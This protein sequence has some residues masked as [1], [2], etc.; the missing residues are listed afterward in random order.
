MLQYTSLAYVVGLP[1][2]VHLPRVGSSIEIT[3]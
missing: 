1:H 2:V 3:I